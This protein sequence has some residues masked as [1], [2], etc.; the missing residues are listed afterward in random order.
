M[1]LFPQPERFWSE[2]GLYKGSAT[3]YV[4]R[5][6]L[7]FGLIA[8]LVTLIQEHPRLHLAV[9]LTPYEILG[10][11]LGALLV[12]RTN[13]G[14]ERWWEARKLWGGMVN[15][16]RNLVIQALAYGP[17]DPEW[18]R[19]MVVWTAAFAHVSRRSLR[20]QPTV[21]ELEPLVGRVKAWRVASA[22]HMPS[23][24]SLI[25]GWLLHEG[26]EKGMDR[27]AFNRAEEQRSRL[28]DHIGACER[29]LKTP[30]PLAYSIQIRQ[31]IFVFLVALPFG[32]IGKVET[33]TPIVTML[34]AYPILALD[35][36]GVELQNPF[37]TARLNHLPLDD[38]CVNIEKNLMFLLI[39]REEIGAENVPDAHDADP[40]VQDSGHM[41][42]N[43]DPDLEGL[44]GNSDLHR[45]S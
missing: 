14:Y 10:A 12:L 38:I 27:L 17:D 22:E 39:R 4:L 30:I 21:P 25:L 9:P 16:C 19:Q 33:L 26:L 3:P 43:R 5:R 36:I 1:Q 45:R 41:T 13:S 6:T 23:A 31:F 8:T 7:L 28:I 35:E 32:I 34:V 15:Q 37:S 2:I 42:W 20:G 24:V 18:R 11:A 40:E 29:I 44:G